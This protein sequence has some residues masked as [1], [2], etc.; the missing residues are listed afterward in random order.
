MNPTDR[1]YTKSHEWVKK[2]GAK[3]TMGITD[4]AQ[5]ALGD[6][7]FIELPS[8]GKKVVKGKECAVVESVKAASDIYAP[9]SGTVLQTNSELDSTPEIVNADPYGKGWICIID[10][11][12]DADLTDLLDAAGYEAFLES[13]A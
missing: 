11:V 9:V 2:E 8:V 7:T 1:K 12:A 4:H 10:Q 3:V 5:D 13:E 6:I